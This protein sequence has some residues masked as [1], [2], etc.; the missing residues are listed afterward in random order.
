MIQLKNGVE[1][2]LPAF[3]LANIAFSGES[4]YL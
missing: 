4:A 3:A 1:E 2:Y